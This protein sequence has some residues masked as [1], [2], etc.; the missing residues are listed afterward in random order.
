MI[1]ILKYFVVKNCKSQEITHRT[2]EVST[3]TG[4][5]KIGLLFSK[6]KIILSGGHLFY[7]VSE[8]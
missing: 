7:K 1:M 2:H 8:R 3:E 4:P 6:N 5:I